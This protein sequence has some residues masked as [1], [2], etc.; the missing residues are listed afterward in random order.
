MKRVAFVGHSFHRKTE[1]ANFFIDFLLEY[2]QIEFYW[3]LPSSY[4]SDLRNFDLENKTYHAVIFF[5][6][7]PTPGE[8]ELI[9]SRN[10]I[11]V[12]MFDNDPLIT[13]S[14]WSKY[15]KYKFINFSRT[16]FSKLEFLNFQRNIYLQFAPTVPKF[17]E[18][19]DFN[20]KPKVFFWQRSEHINWSVLKKLIDFT[21]ISSLH[22]H[23]IEVDVANDNWFEIPEDQDFETCDITFSSWFDSK[24]ELYRLL[25]DCDIFVAP[26]LF[27]GIGQIFI[28]AMAMGKCVISPNFPTMNEYIEDGLNGILFDMIDPKPIDFRDWRRLGDQACDSI[29]RIRS[30]WDQKKLDIIY[31]IESPLTIE[32]DK[33]SINDNFRTLEGTLCE[34]KYRFIVEDLKIDL[35]HSAVRPAGLGFSLYLNILMDYLSSELVPGET[36]IVYGTGTGARLILGL[37]GPHSVEY[38]ID[39]DRRKHGT[40]YSEKPVFGPDKLRETSHKIIISVFGRCNKVTRYLTSEHG[41]EAQRLINLDFN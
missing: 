30:Q 16:L 39:T 24:D 23:R 40:L 25:S 17:R 11:L 36:Y 4:K 32:P 6:I 14:Q 41:I 27:E 38:F 9:V 3:S 22:L 35:L 37:I 29:R 2:Y 20:Q 34:E 15:S 7:L 1:S 5:Q 26:R 13:L 33:G 28:E 19:R 10:I 21:Q 12:P 18:S 8:L 31:L